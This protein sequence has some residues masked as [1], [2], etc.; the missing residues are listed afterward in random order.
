[1]EPC[2]KPKPMSIRNG[3]ADACCTHLKEQGDIQTIAE[4]TPPED[5]GRV[6]ERAL[7]IGGLLAFGAEGFSWAT[8]QEASWPT[9]ALALVSIVT[10]GL[11]TLKNGWI[12]LKKSHT[13]RRFFDVLGHG[14]CRDP[15]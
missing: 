8:G 5:A 4:G 13:H 12:A 3:V 15:W 6:W 1:M 11:P 10:T 2:D 7:V 9:V 14:R